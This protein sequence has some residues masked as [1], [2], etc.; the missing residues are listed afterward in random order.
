MDLTFRGGTD[1]IGRSCIQ[2]SVGEM[3]LL[4]DCGL[5]QAA[6]TVYPDLTGI[7]QGQIDAVLLTHAHID[8]IG[9]LPVLEARD[10]LAGSAPILTTHPTDALATIMLW[11][12]YQLHKRE[13]AETN[14]PQAYT[15]TDVQAVLNRIE[16]VTYGTHD[17]GDYQVQFGNAGHLL[18]S[19]WI[20]IERAPQRILISGDLGGRSGH[21]PAIESPPPADVL[22]LEST[23]GATP[24]HR[25]FRDARTELFSRV[26]EA[27]ATSTPVLIPTFAMGRAQEIL[28]VFREREDEL[29][30][31]A[32]IVYDGMI[33]DTTRAYHAFASAPWVN[34][35]ITNYR[36]ESGGTEPF[37]PDGARTPETMADRES[38]FSQSRTPIIVAPSGMLT[39]GWSPYYLWQLTEQVD[40]ARV[41]FVGHQATGTP[42]R[43]LQSTT[44]DKASVTITALMDADQADTPRSSDEFGFH[45]KTIKV[46]T[47]WLSTIDGLSGHAAANTLLEFVRDA[48][49]KQ[50]HLVHGGA[51]GRSELA[52]YLRSNTDVSAIRQPTIGDQITPTASGTV[53]RPS[54][55]LAKL[56]A[57]RDRLASQL[58]DLATRINELEHR[59]K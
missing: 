49:P 12:A 37:L 47:T 44:D 51:D 7:S 21:L 43:V 30:D 16:G 38:I 8:H 1:E 45:E 40:A 48:T 59:I 31:Q 54:D 42:G 11:D 3:D 36:L 6:S 53:R 34:D 15:E 52:E 41:L 20:A 17:R 33:T 19:A 35:A 13:R 10:L 24:T 26:R 23:Y 55:E 58:A 57:E 9:A 25:S 29:P 22:L 2:V 14:T 32:E 5:K 39:G 28:Q 46:P 27:V 18:G 56:Q 50:V 4:V